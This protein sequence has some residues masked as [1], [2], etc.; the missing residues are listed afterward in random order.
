MKN[1]TKLWSLGLLLTATMFM[2]SCDEDEPTID[3]DEDG[4]SVADGMYIALEGEDPA[5][6]MQLTSEQVEDE[7]FSAQERS[8]FVTGY[9]YLSAG[10]Y[11]IVQTADREVAGTFGGSVETI[12][13]GTEDEPITYDVIAD[14]TDGGAAFSIEEGLYKIAHDELTSEIMIF[15]INSVGLIGAA[16]PNGGSSDTPLSGSADETGG[17]WSASDLILRSGWYKFRF[18]ST[19]GVDRRV[20]PALGFGSDNGYLMFTNF[21]GSIDNL[22]PGNV[23]GNFEMA[24]E[25]EGAYDVEVSYTAEAGFSFSQNRTG[26]APDVTFDPSE[27]NFGI[28]G[29]TNANAF[30]SDRDMVYKEVNGHPTWHGVVYFA[31]N[32]SDDQGRRF[33]FRTNDDWD[34]NLGGAV[35]LGETTTLAVNGNDIEA[36]AAGAYYFMLWTED[37][38]TTWQV[39]T[40]Q[41]GW[42][43]IG[44]GSPSGNWDD[45]TP[46]VAQ[47]FDENGVTTYTYSGDFVGGPYKLRAGSAWDYN[48][49]GDLSA[50]SPDG[51]DLSIEAGNYTFTLTFDGSSYSATVE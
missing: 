44:A 34:F 30:D 41:P 4:L 21:G 24:A 45:E 2:V 1:L 29:S 28:L 51:A 8:G 13:Y 33:K 42:A 48:L 38:G 43:L 25:N 46:L 14:A 40:K 27:Y 6:T 7:G 39:T 11:N 20:D 16:T 36:P 3:V 18:N 37:E 31:E 49:G 10:N 23:G 15:K 9:F 19:W 5:A 12:N 47:G 50:L 26:D 35:T 22:E 17:S 32:S